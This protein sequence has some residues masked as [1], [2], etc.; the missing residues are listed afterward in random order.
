M[1]T[2]EPR[3]IVVAGAGAAGLSVAETARAAGYQGELLILGR[4]RHIPYDRPPLSKQ[5]L[6]GTWHPDRTFLRQ[7]DHLDKLGI[8]VRVAEPITGLDEDA[9]EV[10]LA[11][12]ERIWYDALAIATGV[13][14]RTLPNTEHLSGLHVLRDL[15][16][17]LALRDTL[18]PGHRLVIIGAGVLGSEVAA[19]AAGLGVEVTIIDPLD[20]PMARVVGHEI[21]QLITELHDEHGVR[22]ILGA[23]VSN[24]VHDAGRVQGVQLSDG[25]HLDA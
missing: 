23:G 1:N 18:N 22:L 20:R 6:S 17:A 7:Q 8:T 13:N 10:V 4:E 11:G 3:R 24:F 25:R 14:P 12:G 16:H 19:V 2:S 21:S 9:R 5:V 15:D